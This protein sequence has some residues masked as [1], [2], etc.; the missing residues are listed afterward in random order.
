MTTTVSPVTNGHS[1]DIPQHTQQ[2]VL[3]PV[4]KHRIGP[5]TGLT[6]GFSRRSFGSR[7]S[8][9]IWHSDLVG[10]HALSYAGTAALCDKIL[11]SRPRFGG[12]ELGGVFGAPPGGTAV[13][14]SSGARA[15]PRARFLEE[16]EV[17]ASGQRGRCSS[18][19]F[20]SHRR[21]LLI[22]ARRPFPFSEA[23]AG[24][25]RVL[26]AYADDIR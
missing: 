1:Y 22:V 17:A 23:H 4:T 13:N 25:F 15:R 20:P 8:L 12:Q 10:G 7:S 26:L 9:F 16:L 21:H 18:L 11:R 6:V 2:R 5:P 14:S 24:A 19:L 3:G